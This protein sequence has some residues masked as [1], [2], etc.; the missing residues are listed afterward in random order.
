MSE[1]YDAVVVGAGIV[2]CACAYYLSKDFHRVL[3]VD[4]GPVG[5]GATAEGMGHLV[6]MDDS[7][8]QMALTSYSL[9]LWSELM[10]DMPPQCEVS[11][12]GTIWIA[13]TDDELKA[14]EK[15]RK[16]YD[17][18][19]VPS[20]VI[21]ESTLHEE[22]PNL[23]EGLAGGLL[24]PNDVVVYPPTAAGWLLDKAKERGCRLLQG[25][26]VGLTGS[27]VSLDDGSRI[28]A[29]AVV[30][31]AGCNA[32][33]LSPGI[34]IEPRKGHLA[35]TERYPGFVRR[36]LVELGYLA[37]AHASTGESVAFNVQPRSTG[38]LLIGSSRQF[39]GW[40]RDVDRRIL[41]SMLRRAVEFMPKIGT[42]S[43]IRVWTGF[44]PSTPSK[45]PFI[46]RAAADSGVY[47]ATGHEGLGITTSLG[48]GKMLSDMIAG[49]EPEIDPA[50]YSAGGTGHA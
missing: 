49:R 23:R 32:A 3:I 19:G 24:V 7:D 46:G 12:T 20:E 29:G 40:E 6:A 15:K 1:S 50:P 48:T 36:Q 10:D 44:R 25:K 14:A 33:E 4:P 13:S 28:A 45:L 42:L 22:E 41:A 30:N 2:G 43:S 37:S 21:D 34:A 11:R 16:Y 8:A 35:I 38:Q 39:A 9:R 26:A 27:E 17:S 47:L 31:A 18:Y 5:G